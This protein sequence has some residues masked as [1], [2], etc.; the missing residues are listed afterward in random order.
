VINVNI[1]NLKSFW[2]VVPKEAE[3]WFFILDL[4]CVVFISYKSLEA[5]W[6][7]KTKT[8]ISVRIVKSIV[9]YTEYLNTELLTCQYLPNVTMSKYFNSALESTIG[10]KVASKKLLVSNKV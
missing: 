4:E 2:F 3:F 6:I 7:S 5:G 10:Y 8:R 1:H 9:N